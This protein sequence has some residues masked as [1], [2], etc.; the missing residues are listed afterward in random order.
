[1]KESEDDIRV[2]IATTI[3]FGPSSLLLFGADDSGESS[4]PTPHN[5]AWGGRLQQ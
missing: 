2:A 4:R 3:D 5:A 1:V